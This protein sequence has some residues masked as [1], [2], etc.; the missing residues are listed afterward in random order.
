MG[1]AD[2]HSSWV[3]LVALSADDL[4]V[5]SGSDNKT[6]KI[7]DAR[8]G[9][10]EQTLDCREGPVDVVTLDTSKNPRMHLLTSRG[11]IVVHIGNGLDEDAS[12]AQGHH[13]TEA[14]DTRS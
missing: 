2:G 13:A 9:T 7:W 14:M 5:I 11:W 6:I 10:C 8:T 12:E 1:C 3:E 4:H